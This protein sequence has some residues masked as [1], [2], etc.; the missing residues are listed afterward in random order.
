MTMINQSELCKQF[1]KANSHSN[2]LND[3]QSIVRASMWVIGKEVDERV[4]WGG[5]SASAVFQ[6][7]IASISVLQLARIQERFHSFNC[8]EYKG[9]SY[10]YLSPPASP[11]SP[12]FGQVVQ[13]FWDV[14][15]DVL[16]RITSNNDYDN[17]WS[18]NCDYNFGTW[19]FWCEV[20]PYRPWP[21]LSRFA[22]LVKPWIMRFKAT[23]FSAA[24]RRLYRMWFLTGQVQP[25]FNQS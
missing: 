11:P 3:H 22:G 17:D 20:F 8:E 25:M 9:T 15:N 18:N 14:K 2:Q 7:I 21:S 1:W 16:M 10:N 13:L 23:S 24:V 6:E 19:W 5:N 4:Q 12:K